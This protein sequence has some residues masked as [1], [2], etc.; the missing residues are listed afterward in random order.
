MVNEAGANEPGRLKI[1]VHV[2]D[3]DLRN[4]VRLML[5]VLLDSCDV[6]LF[7]PNLIDLPDLDAR[8][9]QRVVRTRISTGYRLRRAMFRMFGSVPLRRDFYFNAIRRSTKL[10]AQLRWRARLIA[11]IR[12]NAW[13]W[14]STERY[15]RGIARFDATET[16]GIDAW[17]FLTHIY[18]LPLLAKAMELTAPTFLYLHS[19]DH[20]CKDIRLPRRG[21]HYF[22]WNQKSQQDLC[23]Y[24]SISS[25]AVTVCGST[26]LS[27]VE[28]LRPDVVDQPGKSDPPFF[29]YVCGHGY[30]GLAEQELELVRQLRKAMDRVDQDLNLVVRP[31]PNQASWDSYFALAEHCRLTIDGDY[32]SG[33][34]NREQ[35]EDDILHKFQLIHR[36]T[37]VWHCGTTLGLEAAFFSSPVYMFVPEG[38]QLGATS[39]DRHIARTLTMQ[40]LQRY[41]VRSDS[42]NV[43]R[44]KSQLDD[45]VQQAFDGADATLDYNRQVSA[46]FPLRPLTDVIATMMTTIKSSIGR[47][48]TC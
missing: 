41:L 45:A 11:T 30:P 14:Y 40:H 46:D 33:K 31:Y 1:G 2:A 19:W 10:P 4:D 25:E 39:A 32:R 36:S 22:V 15:L 34:S 35:S 8:I 27:Y 16:R 48:S 43:V 24:H 6:V 20:V 28:R 21:V 44:S 37:A 9:E 47:E 18:S 23:H 12:A 7:T 17:L 38:W 29:Y 26:Q 5:R 3:L 13:L 42:P